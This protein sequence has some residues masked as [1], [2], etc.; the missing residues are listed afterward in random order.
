[1]LEERGFPVGDYI[2][3][4]T[5][6]SS[7]TTIRA[8]GGEW[9]ARA[10]ADIDFGVVDYC[11]F[12]AGA[13]ISHELVPRAAQAGARVIDNTTAFRMDDNVPLV[14]PEINARTIT[15]DTRIASCPNCTTIVM[16]MALAPLH[17]AEPIK[18]VV[19][20]SFQSVSGAGKSALEELEAQL[21]SDDAPAESI[22]RRIAFNCVPQVGNLAER[23]FSVEEEKIIEETRKILA[24]PDIGVMPTAVRV[25]VRVGHAVSVN[26]EFSRP[27]ELDDA[28]ALWKKADGVIFDEGYATPH[29]VAGTD[30]VIVGR[31]RRDPSNPAAL[32]FWA[33]GDNL[34]KGA[35]TNSVQIAEVML[36]HDE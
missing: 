4:A 23:G 15:R 7:G 34:R 6:A 28:V 11:F 32:S 18:R 10:V 33:V 36:E 13:A 30:N 3:V 1:V 2:P 16:V 20:T 21:V 8:F 9:A 35:A 5:E 22:P 14:V 17:M 31:L 29:E 19:V 26:V 27:V 24:S 25:P 12:T